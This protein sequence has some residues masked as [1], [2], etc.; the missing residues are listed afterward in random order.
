VAQEVRTRL[1]Y[2][3]DFWLNA[4]VGFLAQFGLVYFVWRAMFAESGKAAI[5]GY[6]PDEMVVYY[7]TVIVLGKLVAG[8]DLEGQVARDIY[9]GGINRYLVFPA[10]YLPFKYAQHLGTM[11]PSAIPFVLLGAAFLTWVEVPAASAPS[12]Q[13]VAMALPALALASVLHYLLGFPIQLVAFWADNVWSLDVAKRFAVTFL[14]GLAIPL[15]VFPSSWQG[16]L[17]V[18]PFQYF[19]YFPARA[20]LGGLTA[21]EW[22]LGMAIGLAWCVVFA[23]TSWMVWRRGQLQYTGIGI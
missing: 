19:Y 1:S 12:L 2:R 8:R 21:G 9:E 13:G 23:T 7:L 10:P 18:L 17:E 16:V 3:L 22:A 15:T 14:G 6:T 5:A 4:I 11:I 20:L